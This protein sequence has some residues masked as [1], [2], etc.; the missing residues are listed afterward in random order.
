MCSVDRE[1]RWTAPPALA[2]VVVGHAGRSLVQ[3]EK[4]AGPV[5]QNYL[6]CWPWFQQAPSCPE[7]DLELILTG[8]VS[9]P[10]PCQNLDE[11]IVYFI[12]EN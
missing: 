3:G 9:D 11:D 5:L 7:F 10:L 8:I 12:M 6:H 2:G 1:A 4:T